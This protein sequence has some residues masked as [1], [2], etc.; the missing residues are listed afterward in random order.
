MGKRLAQPALLADGCLPVLPYRDK[1]L[2]NRDAYPLDTMEW[3]IVIQSRSV[4]S[5]PW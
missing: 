2:A 1:N 3:A 5:D 4:A